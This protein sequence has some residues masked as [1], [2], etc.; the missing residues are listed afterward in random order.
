MAYYN[1]P[2]NLTGSYNKSNFT[3]SNNTNVTVGSLTYLPTL[4]IGGGAG[5]FNQDGVVASMR[6]YTADNTVAG[7]IGGEAV[8]NNIQLGARAFFIAQG[9][10]TSNQYFGIQ[11]GS[12]ELGDPKFQMTLVKG[13]GLKISG[14]GL[15]TGTFTESLKVCGDARITSNLTLNGNLN[16]ITPTQIGYLTNTNTNIKTKFDSLDT[17]IT[18]INNTSLPSKG[19]LGSV[20]S[21]SG[22]NTFT[23]CPVSTKSP[24]N[25]N[26]FESR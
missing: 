6:T 3:E 25:P 21:W 9:I 5:N 15:D 16:G 19:G 24:V 2:S 13:I 8:Y 1:A 10:D 7:T 20:N 22:I 23:A 12:N 26:D 17:S 18:T 11:G 14:S 4:K